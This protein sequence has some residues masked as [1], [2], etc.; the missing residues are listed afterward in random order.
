MKIRKLAAGFTAVATMAAL[1]CSVIVSAADGFAVSISNTKTAAGK[2]FTL[3]LD[4]SGVPETGINGCEFGIK[5][6]NSIVNVSEVTLGSIA[7]A[8]GSSDLPAVFECNI[9]TD[10]IDVMY[11]AGATET[12]NYITSDGTFLNIKGTVNKNAEAGAKADFSIVPIE[13]KVKPGSNTTNTDVIF[14]YMSA[15]EDAQNYEAELTGGYVEVEGA[16]G[17]TEAPTEE[18]TSAPLPTAAVPTDA[19]LVEKANWGDVN[20]DGGVH[21]D[22]VVM[23][24]QYLIDAASTQIEDQGLVNANCVFDDELNSDDSNAILQFVAEV[25]EKSELGK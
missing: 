20:E 21:A 25:I 1:A 4:M 5:Y 7:S 2:E 13:R 8:E 9:E 6:D 10:V 15:G 16:V 18:P 22:D 11:A 14:G 17:P 12:A 3:T 19:D 24:N 23:L